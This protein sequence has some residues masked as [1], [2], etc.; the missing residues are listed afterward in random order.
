MANLKCPQV[1]QILFKLSVDIRDWKKMTL[2]TSVYEATICPVN[3]SVD[4]DKMDK[5]TYKYS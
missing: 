1:P 4:Q 3:F 5:K 2:T